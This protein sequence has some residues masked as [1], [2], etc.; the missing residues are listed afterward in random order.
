MAHIAGFINTDVDTLFRLE[1]KITE[2]IRLNFWKD[3]EKTPIELTTSSWKVA[4]KKQFFFS[5][6]D[7]KNQSDEQ[8]FWKEEQ[9]WR[10]VN[11]WIAKDEPSSSRTSIEHF[12]KVNRNTTLYSMNGIKADARKRIEQDV[13]L[14]LKT[15]NLKNDTPTI[16]WSAAEKL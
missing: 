6:A 15:R 5:Q 3:I 9:S 10:A 11:G 12:T 13:N 1:L 14:E 8:N 7:N 2:T 4:D 16:W